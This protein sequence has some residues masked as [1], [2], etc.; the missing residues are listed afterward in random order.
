VVAIV[1]ADVIHAAG[2]PQRD[3]VTIEKCHHP[4]CIFRGKLFSK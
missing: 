1:I 4:G 3:T 2:Y